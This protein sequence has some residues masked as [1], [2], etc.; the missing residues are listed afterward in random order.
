MRIIANPIIPTKNK[1]YD[2]EI[3]L[4]K[5]IPL[6]VGINILKNGVCPITTIPKRF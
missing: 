6:T 3:N 2:G 1:L 4:Q 5:R